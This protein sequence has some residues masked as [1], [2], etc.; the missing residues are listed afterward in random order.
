MAYHFNLLL[1]AGRQIQEA[2]VFPKNQQKKSPEDFSS[3]ESLSI[4]F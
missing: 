3:G 1:K 4:Q 2:W